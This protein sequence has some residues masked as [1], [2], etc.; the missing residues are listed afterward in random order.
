MNQIAYSYTDDPLREQFQK[1]GYIHLTDANIKTWLDHHSSFSSFKSSWNDL[2]SD[3][4]LSDS[5]SYRYRRYA[6]LNS[7]AGKLS[8][9]PLEAHYQTRSYNPING[10]YYR[11]FS[12]V[13]ASILDSPILKNLIDW[14]LQLISTKEPIDWRI[15]CHQFRICAS[16]LEAGKP[17]PEGIHQDGSDY[18]FIML[19]D[20]HN[21]IG[22]SNS[23][24]DQQGN[25]LYKTVMTHTGEMILLDD[26]RHWHGVSEIHP[27]EKNKQAYRDVFVMTFH[28]LDGQV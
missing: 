10:G 8:K 2:P 13:E 7:I 25:T 27:K 18:V 4:H 26:K 16:E 22:A 1:Q 24:H 14:N 23:I 9:L 20:R 19:I 12:E 28:Q 15:Q 3:N 11:H 5:G 21:I 6:V 17:S